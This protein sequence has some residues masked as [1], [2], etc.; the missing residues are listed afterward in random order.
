[1]RHTGSAIGHPH[2]LVSQDEGIG[3]GTY[4]NALHVVNMF[5][6][7]EVFLRGSRY[8]RLNVQLTVRHGSSVPVS[9]KRTR[10]SRHDDEPKEKIS[11]QRRKGRTACL[12]LI[13]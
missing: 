1:M 13:R 12:T 2:S 11:L 7:P 5:C 9:T 10:T 3:D 6:S 8:G 4:R